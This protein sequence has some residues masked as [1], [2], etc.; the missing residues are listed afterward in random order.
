MKESECKNSC[1]HCSGGIGLEYP[2]FDDS[3]FWVVC[4]AHPLVEG[5]ILVIPKEHISC[6]GNLSKK[7]FLRYKE[8][9]AQV[10]KFINENYGPMAAFEHGIIGQTVFHA[11]TH[12]FPFIGEIND[13][14]PE[15]NSLIK[16]DSKDQVKKEFEMCNKYLFVENANEMWLVDTSLGFPRFFREIF[17]KLLGVKNR[18]DWKATRNNAELMTQFKEDIKNLEKKWNEFIKNN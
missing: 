1:A 3:S 13:I 2:L 5:H 4:D 18:A 14:I 11:H 9:Y 10:K 7:D 15:T 12:F 16:I 6:M 8:L 17:S